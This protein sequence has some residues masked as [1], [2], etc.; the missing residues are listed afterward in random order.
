MFFAL[1][2]RTRGRIPDHAA[3]TSP[4]RILISFGSMYLANCFR[5]H[6]ISFSVGEGLKVR[7]VG[8]S[9]VPTMVFPCLRIRNVGR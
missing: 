5:I 8:S 6:S 9:V 1:G 2:S 7:M 3:N 4:R